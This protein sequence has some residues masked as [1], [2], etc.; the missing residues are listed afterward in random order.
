MQLTDPFRVGISGDFT[1]GQ[2]AGLLEPVLDEI[3]GPVPFVTTD[4]FPVDGEVRPEHVRDFDAVIG[5]HPHFTPASF[6]GV[7]RLAVIARWG[8]GYDTINVPACT[9]NDVLLAITT[10]AVRRPVAEAIVTLILA[11]A[12]RL[13][14]K[15]RL[16]RTAR[17]DLKPQFTGLG[18]RGKTL[19][20]VGLGNIGSEMFRLL[21]PFDLGRRLA[22]DPYVSAETAAELGVELV[23][24]ETLFAGSD[25][26][27][28]NCPLNDRT[29]GMIDA[30]LLA[31]MKPTAYFVNTARG[32]I[33]KQGDLVAVLEAGG[34]AGAGLDV[35]VQ[36]P[37]P[38]DHPLTRLDN[39]ILAPHALA[40]TDDIYRGNSTG[41]IANVLTVLH[42]RVPR[43]TVNPEVVQR[44]GFRAKLRAL[45]ERW[46]ALAE[47][48]P[49]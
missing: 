36:E 38:A 7:E 43:H 25:F 37:L 28:V 27:A 24:L 26:I 46:R 5:W 12:K 30:R 2:A 1:S 22:S 19:G 29:R 35:F 3:L 32:G 10:D 17:W 15:D 44:A 33:V 31:L 23:D 11:L 14:A 8:V 47:V 45:A 40:W 49:S 9:A 13:P 18:L 41:S 21:A 34:I 20:S 42:G 39:V 4:Y 6:V 48:S 16:V